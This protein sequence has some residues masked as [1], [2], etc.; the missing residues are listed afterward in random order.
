[1]AASFTIESTRYTPTVLYDDTERLLDISG[2]SFPENTARF[3]GQVEEQI[4]KIS[5][6]GDLKLRF[7]FE[8]LNSSSIISVLKI[9]K[10]F[11]NL[12]T[13]LSL[14]WHYDAGD[15][16]IEN[17]GKDID[18]LVNSSVLFSVAE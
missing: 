10:H 15:E 3:Y 5:T 2:R 16:E 8:Y 18:R 9:I 11:E 7:Y 4:S 12:G 14:E 17:V 13:N 6:E 1:M